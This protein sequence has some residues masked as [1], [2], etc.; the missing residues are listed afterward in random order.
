VVSVQANQA[1]VVGG[2]NVG[3]LHEGHRSGRRVANAGTGQVL[4]TADR[5]LHDAIAA[6]LG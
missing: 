3:H 6:G 5:D 2:Q 4:R 1:R